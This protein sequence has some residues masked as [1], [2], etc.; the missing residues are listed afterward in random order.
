MMR[1]Q[2]HTE[3]RLFSIFPCAI[4]SVLHPEN[5]AVR[6]TDPC[7]VCYQDNG[8]PQFEI[9]P[10]KKLQDL[11]RILRIQVDRGFFRQQ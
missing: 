3:Q 6:L 9:T 5:A 4:T 10:M 1:S 8:L 7:V 2:G 11:F